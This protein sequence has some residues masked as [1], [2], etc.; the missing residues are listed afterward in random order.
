MVS[1]QGVFI[2]SNFNWRS[3]VLLLVSAA[4]ISICSTTSETLVLDPCCSHPSYLQAPSKQ[5][6]P[7][8]CF[9]YHT[10]IKLTWGIKTLSPA[11]TLQ[12][13]LFPSLSKPPGPTAKTLASLSSLTLDSGRKIPLA[14]LVSA[15]ILWTKTRSRRGARDLMDLR[16]VDCNINVH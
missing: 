5:T 12:L 8:P 9:I 10:L 4:Q 1:E 11:C 7:G 2:F 13:T 15:L 3:S 14:V 16:A 6:P